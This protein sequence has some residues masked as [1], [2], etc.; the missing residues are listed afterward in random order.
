VI[1]LRKNTSYT[2]Q[3]KALEEEGGRGRGKGG[4]RGERGGRGHHSNKTRHSR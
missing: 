3:H 4:R 1:F 2:H